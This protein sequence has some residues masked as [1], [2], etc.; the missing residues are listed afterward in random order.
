MNFEEAGACGINKRKF[1][2]TM[3]DDERGQFE[4]FLKWFG[5]QGK[6]AAAL[7]I[8][9]NAEKNADGDNVSEQSEDLFNPMFKT[10]DTVCDDIPD[11]TDYKPLI[12]EMA[13]NM[14]AYFG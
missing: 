8:P 10:L 5:G 7:A 2:I 6:D 1:E 13:D 3:S 14:A 12:E 9:W 4:A 11:E